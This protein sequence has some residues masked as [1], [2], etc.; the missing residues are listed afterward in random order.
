MSL[1]P[2]PSRAVKPDW[3]EQAAVAVY[4]RSTLIRAPLDAVWQFHSTVD[5]LV[6]ITPDWFGLTVESVVGPAGES[7]P[8]TLEAGSEVTLSVKPFGIG[9]GESWTSHITDRKRERE[10]AVLRDEMVDGP[11]PR[12]HHTHRF[13]AEPGGTRLTDRVEY[14]LPL[15][16]ARGLSGLGWPGFEAVFAYR[17][18][19]ARQLLE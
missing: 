3:F 8:E 4:E 11:F 18:R 15:G 17:H 10:T 6:A 16:P 19:R 13:A 14:E 1:A 9:P 7:E 5:G 2:C 12:W